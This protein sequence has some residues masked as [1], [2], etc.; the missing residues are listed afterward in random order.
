MLFM[1]STAPHFTVGVG[2]RWLPGWAHACLLTQGVPA[3]SGPCSRAIA[4]AITSQ[5]HFDGRSCAFICRRRKGDVYRPGISSAGVSASALTCMG[6]DPKCSLKFLRGFAPGDSLLTNMQGPFLWFLNANFH[7]GMWHA[8]CYSYNRQVSN[9]N[10]LFRH[11]DQLQR[12]FE[13]A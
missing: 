9:P 13:A 8:F 11:H 3:Y 4:H 6:A 1:W 2:E 12:T 7:H 10:S 5:P